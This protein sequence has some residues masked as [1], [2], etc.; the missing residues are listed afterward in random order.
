[1]TGHD[2]RTIREACGI[3]REELA[4][5]LEWRP[6]SVAHWESEAVPDTRATLDIVRALAR[7]VRSRKPVAVVC[8]DRIGPLRDALE[9]LARTRRCGV[10]CLEC[11]ARW[12]TH[13]SDCATGRA[14][15]VLQIPADR[16]GA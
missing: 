7:I 6:D 14:L 16:V 10:W 5:A 2:L 11:R 8:G 3:T 1:M 4:A 12:T 9:A 15:A 13:A